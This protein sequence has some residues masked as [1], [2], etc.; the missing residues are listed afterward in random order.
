MASGRSQ[1]FRTA[2]ETVMAT[3][4]TAGSEDGK[5]VWQPMPANGFARDLPNQAKACSRIA[6]RGAPLPSTG[7]YRF[8]WTDD[9][10]DGKK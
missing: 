9:S 5:N 6:L 1:A 7:R 2:L 8:G 4:A 3:I 10:Y